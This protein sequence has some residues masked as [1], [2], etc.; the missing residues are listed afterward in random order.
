MLISP[1]SDYYTVDKINRIFDCGMTNALSL[2]HCNI[3]CL[4][5]NL[6]LLNE[7]RCSISKKL[8]VIAITETRVNPN[9]VINV[10][11]PGYNF[12]ML[13]Q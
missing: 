11:I 3:R 2:F 13:I 5:K 6:N 9:R 7:M 10:D 12:F 1:M 8:D 4:E